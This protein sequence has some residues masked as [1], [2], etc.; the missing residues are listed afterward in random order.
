MSR[1]IDSTSAA[2]IWSFGA[3]SMAPTIGSTATLNHSEK[4][5]G[6]DSLSMV[7]LSAFGSNHTGT[8]EFSYSQHMPQEQDVES[9]AAE[10]VR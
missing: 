5:S 3:S 8:S 10:Q 4:W 6:F 7:D 2:S 9:R 1:P